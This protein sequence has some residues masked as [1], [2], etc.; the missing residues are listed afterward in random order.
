MYLIRTQGRANSSMPRNMSF[1]LTTPQM[2]Q[3]S[4]TVTRRLGWSYLR[5]GEVINAVE[6]AMGLHKGEKVVTIGQLR[7][8]SVRRE[9][10]HAITADD[11]NREGFPEMTPTQFIQMFCRHNRCNPDTIVTRIEFQHLG[12]G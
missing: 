6:K 3:R 10:L 11:C 4:K 5:V 7:V 9:P 8:I 12:T 2:C 1:S